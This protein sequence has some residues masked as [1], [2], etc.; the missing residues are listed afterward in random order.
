M[1]LNR[2]S[3]CTFKCLEFHIQQLEFEWLH[4]VYTTDNVVYFN[5]VNFDQPTLLRSLS[6]IFTMER[7]IM[8]I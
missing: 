6:H 7:A 4:T 8:L 1:R 2:F 5:I 3:H